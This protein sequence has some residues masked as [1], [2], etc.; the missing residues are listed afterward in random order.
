MNIDRLGELVRNVLTDPKAP[1][2]SLITRP[3][4][5]LERIVLDLQATCEVE[6]RSSESATIFVEDG[7]MQAG[8]FS[9][10]PHY[11]LNIDRCSGLKLAGT[12]SA[13][14]YIFRG[15]ASDSIA[16]GKPTHTSDFR[17][18]Y[19]GSIETIV[20]AEY[21]GKRLF[22]QKGKHSS[23]HFHCAKTETYFIH[24]GRLLIRLR[25]GRGEDR[26]F[27]LPAGSTLDIPPGLMHQSGAIEDTV[28]IEI[29]T[30]DEDSD[31]FLVEDGQRIPMPR[32]RQIIAGKTSRQRKIVFD[33]DGCL[34]SQT[35]GD[36][37]KA[38]PIRE[39]I[40]LVNRLYERGHE[41]VIHTSRFMG[42]SHGDASR[43]YNDGFTFTQLQLHAWGVR[44][45]LLVMGKPAADLVVDDRGVFFR[46]DWDGIAEEIEAEL[47]PLAP[48]TI[49]SNGTGNTQ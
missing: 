44:Y 4:Y 37:E 45:H 47:N 31:S 11:L 9:L 46:P 15:A 2:A 32:L 38:T 28:I 25:A 12:R 29:S 39:A 14:A 22:F 33:L 34:C 6:S 48:L 20:N 42:R 30:H 13:T 23:L 5:S 18:K 19:W 10:A 43:A 36:Y 40:D 16:T 27:E 8:S 35:D 26:W 21:T 24:S 41:I 49:T 1:S 3:E 17:P 7:E